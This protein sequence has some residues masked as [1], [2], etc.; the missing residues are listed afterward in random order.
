MFSVLWLSAGPVSAARG[1]NG[2]VPFKKEL[3][4]SKRRESEL[5]TRVAA[6][7]AEVKAGRSA[8]QALQRQ[9]DDAQHQLQVPHQP[10]KCQHMF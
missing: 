4:Q 9:A 10:R 7:E 1:L 6:L 3:M 5:A 8:K 2:V